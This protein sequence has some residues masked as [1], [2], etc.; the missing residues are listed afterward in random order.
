MEKNRVVRVKL[1]T[2]KKMK[3]YENVRLDFDVQD[4]VQ[5]DETIEEALDRLYDVVDNKLG[6]EIQKFD[7]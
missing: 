5:E 4:E 7:V 2:T 6:T 3:E 1:G